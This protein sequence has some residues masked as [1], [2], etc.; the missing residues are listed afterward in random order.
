V[1]GAVVV[2][3]LAVVAAAALRGGGT[4]PRPD[5]TDFRPTAGTAVEAV[6]PSPHSLE[7][8]RL[9]T[10]GVRFSWVNPDPR[11]DDHYLWRVLTVTGDS[12]L[13][14]L[15]E[16]TVTIPS[17]EAGDEVCIE[18]SIVRAD[19]RVSARPAQACA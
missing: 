18:V 17:A 1:S 16:P 13:E 8:Q 4:D 7:G 6:V 3:A 2:A 15:E 9:S 14:T 12:E 5:D 10:G 11:P 19:R